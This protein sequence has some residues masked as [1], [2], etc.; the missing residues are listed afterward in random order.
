M[1]SFISQEECPIYFWKETEQPYGYLSQ[2]Y[3]A[4]FTTPGFEIDSPPI[5]FKNTEQYMMFHKAILFQDHKTAAQ[6]LE[7]LNPATQKSLGRKVQG[8]NKATWDFQKEKI[9][10]AGNWFKFSSEDNLV[11][12]KLLLET[13][14]RELIEVEADE[15]RCILRYTELLILFHDRLLHLTEFGVLAMVHRRL[16]QIAT[17]GVRICWERRWGEFVADYVQ[18]K[19][20]R[21]EGTLAFWRKTHCDCCS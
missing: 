17:G 7:A 21:R 9:V 16:N 10:E 1:S 3:N 5:H 15:F 20:Q 19:R 11:L 18:V 4:P 6:I 2:W 8:F 14:E 13:G 12:K